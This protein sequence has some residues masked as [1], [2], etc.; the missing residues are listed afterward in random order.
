MPRAGYC[1]SCQA[2]VWLSDDGCCQNGHPAG[3]ITSIREAD[4]IEPVSL[5]RPEAANPK[6]RGLLIGLI[7]AA[8][9]VTLGL[10]GAVSFLAMP[11]AKQGAAATDEWK[12][13]LAKD[14]PGWSVLSF[15][16]RAFSGAEG[17]EMEYSFG[18][19][20]PGRNFAVGVV[21]TSTGG[22]PA[23]SQDLILRP[24]S[25]YHGRAAALLDF[26]EKTYVRQGREVVSVTT[27]PG[28]SATVTWQKVTTLGFFTSRFG[29]FDRLAFDESTGTWSVSAAT[30]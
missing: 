25:Q 15:N 7:I 22:E 1:A 30:P 10:C 21:Y 9:L 12:A 19:V 13:R 26:I 11:F 8:V 6:R 5:P 29:S 16:V 14:Y 23:V 17:S 2:D 18:L 20:P 28:G 3:D 24:G 4:P 27:E